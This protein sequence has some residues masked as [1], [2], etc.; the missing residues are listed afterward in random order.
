VIGAI[1]LWRQMPRLR[2]DMRET[3][4]RMGIIKT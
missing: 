3:Y 1:L 4:T 2:A